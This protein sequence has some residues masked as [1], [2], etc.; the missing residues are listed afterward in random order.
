MTDQ[1][2]LQLHQSL[3]D[4]VMAVIAH[5]Q[6]A[7]IVQPTD[8]RSTGQRSLPRPLPCGVPRR[9][10][11]GVMPRRR[12]ASRCGC[13]SQARSPRSLL[14]RRRGRPQP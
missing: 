3:I 12:K 6:A 14:G 10:R 13:E 1:A 5:T 9:A 2:D 11:R 7:R 8:L 4:K